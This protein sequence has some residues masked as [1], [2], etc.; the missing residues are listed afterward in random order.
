MLADQQ[1]EFLETGRVARLATADATGQPHVVPICYALIDDLVCFTID[2]KP[3]R[4]AGGDLQRL[5]NIRANPKAALV[6]D[7]YDEDWSKLGWIMIQGEADILERGEVHGRAQARLRERYPQLS[8]MRLSHLP[9]VVIRIAR[10]I[11]WGELEAMPA[12]QDANS[13]RS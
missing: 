7:R 8:T 3:K 13:G 9:V 5:A 10:V 6:V 1:R 2:E 4:K 11:S 12:R